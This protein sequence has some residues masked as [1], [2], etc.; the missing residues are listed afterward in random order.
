MRALLASREGQLT[1]DFRLDA[2][3]AKILALQRPQRLGRRP[4][5]PARRS[6]TR[7]TRALAEDYFRA[8]SVLDDGD[9]AKLERSGGGLSQGAR[10]RSVSG[11]GADQPG[12]HSLQ[13]RRARRGAGAVRARDRPRVR[14]LRGAL[15]PRQHLP[16][17][18][19]LR[20][21]AGVLPRS[22][23]P[24]S[25]L[26][27]RAL[28]SGGDVRKDGAVAGGAAALARLP[29]ARAERRVGRAR[30]GILGVK[31]QLRLWASG[32][33]RACSVLAGLQIS[34]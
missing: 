28:L 6:P 5:P 17:P 25:V 29:A 1:F 8:A 10:A 9:E 2:A 18:R 12:E 15:Q 4:R 30:A 31:T 32:T 23:A 11:R 7:E 20:R 27:R 21:G 33:V 26:R 16:R 13:P 19:P 24:Q 14:L 34:A 22:A 3:P